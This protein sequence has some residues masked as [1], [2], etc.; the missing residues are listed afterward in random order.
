MLRNNPQQ[1]TLGRRMRDL[2]ISVTDRC[3][4]RCTYCMPKESF[5][6]DYPFLARDSLLSFEE[7]QRLARLFA[8]L[9]VRKL[10]LTGGEPLVRKNLEGLVALLAG[11]PGIEDIS[12]TTNGSLLTAAKAQALKQA[13]L[14]RI[15]ISLDALDDPTFMAIND[16]GFP[17]AKVLD[18]IDHAK[19]AGL[20][21]VKTNMVVK[22]GANEHSVPEMAGHFRHSGHVLRF[23]E[24]MDVGSSNGWR[25]EDVYTAAEIRTAVHDRWPIEPVDP[26]YQGEVAKRWRYKD[27]AGEI[28]IISS[29]TQP[30]CGDCSRARL[31]AEGSLYTCLFAARGHDLRR[32][33]REDAS[34]EYLREFIA[35]VWARRTDRYSEQRTERTRGLAKVEMSYIGG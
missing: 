34:D 32:L 33:L 26:N 30:F 12:L 9:G 16:V 27:G 10:R 3:N 6:A 22:R 28:G 13:G 14:K 15:T 4:F 7:I 17:V 25:M 21:P 11:T 1:D 20:A 2:R 8:Q 24:Y 19:I 29:V 18:A 5:G 35:G 23:I 31:S